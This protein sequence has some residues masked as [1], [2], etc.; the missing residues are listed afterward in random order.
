MSNSKIVDLVVKNGKIVTSTEI[1]EAGLAIDN[2]KFVLIAKDSLLPKADRVIDAKGNFILPGVIDVHTHIQ[3]PGFPERDDFIWGSKAAAAGGVTT[4]L[5]MPTNI[6]ITTTVEAFN[7]KKKLGEK[8]SITDFGLWGAPDYNNLE[9]MKELADVGVVGFKAFMT[10]SVQLEGIDTGKLLEIFKMA[11]KVDRFVSIHAECT[12]IVEIYTERLK[13]AGRK[14]YKAISEARPVISE[15]EATVRAIT[16]AKEAG[17]KV[18]FVH[19]STPAVLPPIVSAREEGYPIYT[20]TCPHYLFFTKEDHDKI[21]GRSVMYPPL[22]EKEDVLELWRA[23]SDGRISIVSSDHAP[24][25]I[26]DK[27]REVWDVVAGVPGIETLL[28]VMLS[29][30]VNKGRISLPRLVDVLAE[31]PARFFGLYP[32]KGVIRIGSDADL[33]IVDLKAEEKIT[34][35]KLHYKCGFTPF[36][37]YTLKGKPLVTILRGEI[38][39]ED[40]DVIGKPGYGQFIPYKEYGFT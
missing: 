16:L 4:Y 27:D 25:R 37:G 39:A 22:R 15:V 2:G 31:T 28:R 8:K 24:N 32:R 23:V 5:D 29:E 34:I 40:G 7:V 35:N 10:K 13:K 14:D 33:V 21:G 1:Y 3:D 26:E 18:Y 36:E 30:G 11:K 38:I 20:E 6:P 19:Q 12:E 17:N 9:N